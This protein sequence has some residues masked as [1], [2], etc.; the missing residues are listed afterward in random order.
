MKTLEQQFNEI[1]KFKIFEIEVIDNRTNETEYITFDISIGKDILT[2]QH[3]ALTKLEEESN[4]IAFK[5][6]YCDNSFSLDENLQDLYDKCLSA[7]WNSDFYT[8]AN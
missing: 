5:E 3:V 6:S 8:L 2:A 1:T 7:I 4:N